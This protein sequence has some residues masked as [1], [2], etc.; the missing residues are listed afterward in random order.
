MK[1]QPPFPPGPCPY[2]LDDGAYILGALAPANRA[3]FERHLPGCA[4]CRDSMA[5]LNAAN[6]QVY[7]ISVDTFFALKAFQDQQHYNF[8][9]LD[10]KS[11]V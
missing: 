4:P 10:R 5:Q 6:A 3:E 9:L 8:P 11:V 2:E 7:G 1:A